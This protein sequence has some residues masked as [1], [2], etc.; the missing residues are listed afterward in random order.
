MHQR[1]DSR[2]LA[3]PYGGP[4]H[5]QPMTLPS[6]P[7][8]LPSSQQSAGFPPNYPMSPTSKSRQSAQQGAIIRSQQ[9]TSQLPRLNTGEMHIHPP[10]AG[11]SMQTATGQPG[12]PLS[13]S[14]TA[15]QQ[16]SQ[17]SPSIYFHHWQPPTSQPSTSV[18]NQPT[19]PSGKY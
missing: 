12:H 5:Q 19:T 15:G 1:R 8:G 13:Q 18:A 7:I 11:P 14:Q 16:E 10:P 17:S 2:A 6:T 9:Q 4:Q 3:Q